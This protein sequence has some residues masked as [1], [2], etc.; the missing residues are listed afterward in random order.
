MIDVPKPFDQLDHYSATLGHKANHSETPNARYTTYV[1]P[2][3]GPI[4]AIRAIQDILV[5]EEITCEYA[6]KPGTGP[7]VGDEMC[8]W[9]IYEFIFFVKNSGTE[10]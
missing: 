8:E 5:D 4:A 10:I 9:K 3:F 1:H 2:R 7:S 6:F